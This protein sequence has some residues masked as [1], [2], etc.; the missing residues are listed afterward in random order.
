MTKGRVA[1]PSRFDAAEDEQQVPPLR[2][3]GFPVQ[4]GGAGPRHSSTAWQEIR[5]RS[6]RDDT[7]VS[8]RNLQG[9]YSGGGVCW[10]ILAR[11]LRSQM[12]TAMPPRAAEVARRRPVRQRFRGSETGCESSTSIGPD[13][14]LANF[15]MGT[16]F[17][18]GCET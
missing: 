12:A 6:G 2:S 13:L 18:V 14:K 5:V 7:S 16:D 15:R 9:S 3:R 1:L 11:V 8:V 17:L 10:R 4:L